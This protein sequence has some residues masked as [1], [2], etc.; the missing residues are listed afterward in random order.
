MQIIL[1][2]MRSKFLEVV[3]HLLFVLPTAIRPAQE[4][5]RVV[6]CTNIFPYCNCVGWR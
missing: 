2:D 5:K 6:I 4:H 1:I 3:Q